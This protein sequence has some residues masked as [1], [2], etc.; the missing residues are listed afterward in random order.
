MPKDLAAK[1]IDIHA[2]ADFD[3]IH[4]T[5]AFVRKNMPVARARVEGFEPFWFISRFDDV[6]AV[7]ADQELFH[8][9]DKSS[10]LTTIAA[11]RKAREVTGGSPH[12]FRT[13]VHMDNP[14]HGKFREI[15]QDYLRP[16]RLL[17]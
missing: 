7:E 5:Y 4:E 10:T 14:D 2:Y 6:R 11:D 3:A 17:H 1:L 12:I 15:T 9:G 8:A 13:L 16:R